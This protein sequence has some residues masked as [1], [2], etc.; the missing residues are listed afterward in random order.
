MISLEADKTLA[1]AHYAAIKEAE[2][3]NN[4][5]CD[6]GSTPSLVHNLFESPE[7]M[8]YQVSS[9]GHVIDDM[10]LG[11]T[12][13]EFNVKV[14]AVCGCGVVGCCFCFLFFFVFFFFFPQASNCCRSLVSCEEARWCRE[15]VAGMPFSS[16]LFT[17]L[18][19]SLVPFKHQTPPGW[20]NDFLR[21]DV[22]LPNAVGPCAVPRPL[23]LLWRRP[24]VVFWR[25]RCRRR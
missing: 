22:V 25:R 18:I 1:R 16:S 20:R 4:I 6:K 2:A 7:F 15:S 23:D 10:M 8:R 9:M 21:S 19:P 24:A 12:R 3:P 5:V 11:L 13:S 17:T 14:S